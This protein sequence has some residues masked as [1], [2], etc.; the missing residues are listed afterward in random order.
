MDSFARDAHAKQAAIDHYA[1]RAQE[2]RDV[3]ATGTPYVSVV[4][5][6]RRGWLVQTF[7]IAST[8]KLLMRAAASE[9]IPQALREDGA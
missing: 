7:D 2:F 8:A 1:R 5:D 4:T 3:A 6:L 9:Q